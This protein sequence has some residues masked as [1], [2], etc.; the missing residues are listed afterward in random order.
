MARPKKDNADYFSHDKNMRN[1]PKIKALR[2]KFPKEGYSV[3]NM[4]LEVL[5][6]ADF[7]TIELTPVEIE[8][9]AGDFDVEPELLTEIVEYCIKIHLLKQEEN[10]IYSCGLK[11]RLQPVLDNRNAVKQRFL[12]KK[13]KDDTVS[14]T[15]NTQSKVKYSKV[16]ESKEVVVEL[17]E[18]SDFSEEQEKEEKKVI[19]VEIFIDEE[20]YAAAVGFL[21]SH[22]MFTLIQKQQSLK[23][24]EVLKYFETF[25]ETKL[26]LKELKGKSKDEVLKHFLFWIPKFIQSSKTT[27]NGNTNSTP[28]TNGSTVTPGRAR[29]SRADRVANDSASRSQ[30][31]DG[32]RSL[33][34]G[35]APK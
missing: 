33:L 21:K 20:E 3:F 28:R 5:T 15:Q 12:D 11:K 7:F 19:P 8:L 13:L 9:M 1:D 17:E 30:L 23:P 4:L 27:S 2:R 35:T 10:T 6:E 25:Y 34:Q 24:P 14:K 18:T 16:K 31:V 26:A 22:S 32:L 29:V